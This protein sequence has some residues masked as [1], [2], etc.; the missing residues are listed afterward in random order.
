M[1][2]KT[3]SIQIPFRVPENSPDTFYAAVGRVAAE[4]SRIE[5]LM[6]SAIV[7]LMQAKEEFTLPLVSSMSINNKIGTF[8][9][10]V[11]LHKFSKETRTKTQKILKEID[12][13][14][15]ERNKILHGDWT[16]VSILAGPIGV[17][18]RYTKSAKSRQMLRKSAVEIRKTAA[19][20]SRV[21]TRLRSLIIKDLGQTE[22][23]GV[24]SIGHRDGS[25]QYV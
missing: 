24:I 11:E 1:S 12:A 14:R 25:V 17:S 6:D 5:D 22:M 3:D 18:G 23:H 9:E 8:R 13:L 4:W 19:E 7:S 16:L 20:I 2:D 15:M 21:H 10:L